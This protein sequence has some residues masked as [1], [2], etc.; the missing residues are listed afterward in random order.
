MYIIFCLNSLETD[1]GVEC[2]KKYGVMS[3]CWISCYQ[4]DNSL[5][6]TNS[7]SR[8]FEV[9]CKDYSPVI[10]KC[11]KGKLL[12]KTPFLSMCEKKYSF[13][14]LFHC[15]SKIYFSGGSKVQIAESPY[16]LNLFRPQQNWRHRSAT[17]L[18]WSSLC[19]KSDLSH[20]IQNSNIVQYYSYIN[21]YLSSPKH[22]SFKHRTTIFYQTCLNT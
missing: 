11:K 19:A 13:Y 8:S 16:K 4:Q 21:L 22:C 7:N 14:P 20:L 17:M 10:T 9:F 3:E 6:Q 12:D 5:T 15:N 18:F 2:C 1:P